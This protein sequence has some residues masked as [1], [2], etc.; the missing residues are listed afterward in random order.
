MIF[1]LDTTMRFN[2]FGCKIK[3][4][5]L[6]KNDYKEQNVNALGGTMAFGE[7][8]KGHLGKIDRQIKNLSSYNRKES[9]K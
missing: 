3:L 4:L 2:V 7:G 1:Y 8:T 9:D 6:S 5:L